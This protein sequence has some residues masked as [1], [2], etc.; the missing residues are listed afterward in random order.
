MLIL[1][2]LAFGTSR[3][4]LN[5]PPPP[6]GG[7]GAG[8]CCPARGPAGGKSAF[9]AVAVGDGG[10]EAAGADELPQL[11]DQGHRAVTA[12][13]AAN[14]DRQVGLP[15]ALIPR[16]QVVEQV[17]EPAEQLPAFVLE[18]EATDLRSPA[19]LRLELLHDARV[20]QEA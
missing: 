18:D 9:V 3:P 5:P 13:R 15:L 10:G 12:S 19:V 4:P 2:I 6:T 7:R 20:R 17:A 1:L 11:L 16:E 14:R 8:R